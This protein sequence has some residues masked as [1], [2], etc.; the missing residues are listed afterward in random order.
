MEQRTRLYGSG[1]GKYGE[2]FPLK[3]G[4]PAEANKER[5]RSQKTCRG[6]CSMARTLGLSGQIV[7]QNLR[8]RGGR[9]PPADHGSCPLPE[10][11]SS[12]GLVRQRP[13]YSSL[14]PVFGQIARSSV[15]PPDS[16]GVSRRFAQNLVVRRSTRCFPSARLATPLHRSAWK[17]R[18]CPWPS[19]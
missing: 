14:P 6:R 3:R 5:A 15:V 13:N 1:C 17:R 2:V 7:V 10:R 9:F 11:V 4:K 16:S 18:P 19:P 12:L 8:S